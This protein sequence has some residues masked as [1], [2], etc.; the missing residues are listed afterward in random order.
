MKNFVKMLGLAAVCG[1]LMASAPAKA[2][3][4]FRTTDKVI[5]RSYVTAPTT[6]TSTVTFYKPGTVLPETVTYSELPTTVTTKLV[7]APEGDVYVSEGGNVYL[8]N[9]EKR[10]VVDGITV[11]DR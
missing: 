5:L 9:K 4:Y 1:G 10:V 11:Y 8:I 2:D 6:T 7:P 3:T